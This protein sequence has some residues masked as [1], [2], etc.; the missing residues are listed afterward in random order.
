MHQLQVRSDDGQ[1]LLALN[2]IYV[3]HA[4]HQTAR[5]TLGVPDARAERQASSGLIVASGTGATGW[6]RSM[7]LSTG[8]R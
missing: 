8:A 4:S 3:G 7:W 1:Q 5:Y 6:C 2:E